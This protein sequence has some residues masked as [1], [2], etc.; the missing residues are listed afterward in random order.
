MNYTLNHHPWVFPSYF[1]NWQLLA[2][3]T[4]FVSGLLISSSFS[5]SSSW[6]N[7][8]SSGY[9]CLNLED[10]DDASTSNARSSSKECWDPS[11]SLS[12]ASISNNSCWIDLKITS[13][14]DYRSVGNIMKYY[15]LFLM[16]RNP[17]RNNVTENHAK[18][19]KKNR[20]NA[21]RVVVTFLHHIYTQYCT[22]IVMS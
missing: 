3:L 17:F 11:D 1:L 8:G 12:F 18:K 22:G 4:T 14:E 10:D 2:L 16:V 9:W 15:R 19:Q 21:L 5:Q 13:R 20:R 6:T 7:T